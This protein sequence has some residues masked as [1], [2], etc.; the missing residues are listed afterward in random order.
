MFASMPSARV[1]EGDCEMGG[2]GDREG[3]PRALVGVAE[4]TLAMD[5]LGGA[6]SYLGSLGQDQEL[7]SLR[8]FEPLH[9]G[10]SATRRFE[11]GVRR[12]FPRSE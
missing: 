10:D 2:G 3:W 5:A 9:G 4:E 8:R 7:L 6:L 11:L 1:S 12:M